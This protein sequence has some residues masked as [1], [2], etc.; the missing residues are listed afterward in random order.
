MLGLAPD[1]GAGKGKADVC[2]LH[3]RWEPQEP[4]EV[5]WW[6]E[7]TLARGLHEVLGA[8]AATATTFTPRWPSC[9]LPRVPRSG[10]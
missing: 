3:L 7:L 2:S 5:T 4:R 6:P 8:S 9:L 1:A 10:G